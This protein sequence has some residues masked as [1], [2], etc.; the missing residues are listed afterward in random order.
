MSGKETM[1][2]VDA[3]DPGSDSWSTVGKQSFPCCFLLLFVQFFFSQPGSVLFFRWMLF[4]IHELWNISL[5]LCLQPT[6]STAAIG[7]ASRFSTAEFSCSAARPTPISTAV[8]LSTTTRPPING[9]SIAVNCP[10]RGAGWVAWSCEWRKV[11]FKIFWT[12]HW[13][14]LCPPPPPKTINDVS[15]A[16]KIVCFFWQN[17]RRFRG[18][19]AAAGTG[20]PCW[21]DAAVKD[22]KIAFSICKPWFVNGGFFLVLIK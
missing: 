4:N 20:R 8:W 19:T 15:S 14:L 21:L 5:T 9:R 22:G 7:L 10:A 17:F 18:R 2:R 1:C 11:S 6:W 12:I 16:K 13:R 3:Y